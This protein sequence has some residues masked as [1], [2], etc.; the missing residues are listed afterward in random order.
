MSMSDGFR[1]PLNACT[2]A[3]LNFSKGREHSRRLIF[4]CAS[5][6]DQVRDHWHSLVTKYKLLSTAQWHELE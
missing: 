5:K 3:F 4:L 1:I 6:S 2:C